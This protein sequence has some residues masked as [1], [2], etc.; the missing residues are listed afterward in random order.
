MNR[1]YTKEQYLELVEKMKAKIPNVLFSTDIIVGFPG[2]TDEEFEDTL[3]VVRKIN[4]EQIFMFIY[5]PREGTLSAARTD[6]VPDDIKHIRFDKLKELY[7]SRVDENNEK[8][9]N[10]KQQILI[11]GLSKNNSEMLTGRTDTN[12]VVIFEPAENEKIGDIVTVKIEEAHKWYLKA[13]IIH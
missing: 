11:E 2:E 13:K 4:F 9:L 10:T 5:S 7:E 8:Y 6:Q 1:K 3:D 12:K